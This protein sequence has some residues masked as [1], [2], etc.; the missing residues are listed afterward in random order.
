MP[1]RL[2][3]SS[4]PR[5]SSHGHSNAHEDIL[6]HS[7]LRKLELS[8]LL[9]TVLSP[10]FGAALLQYVSSRVLGEDV[11]SWFSTALFVLATGVRPWA[12]VVKRLSSRVTDLHD[13]IHYPS[14]LEPAEEYRSQLEEMKQQI[15]GFEKALLK[16]RQK[17]GAET[18][19]LYDYVDDA[20]T[21]LEKSVKRHDKR[22]EKYE[23]RLKDLEYTVDR[24]AHAKGKEKPSFITVNTK[25]PPSGYKSLSSLVV[26][27]LP[28]WL[29]PAQAVKSPSHA[30][31][32]LS[33]STIGPK[34]PPR[35]PSYSS[36]E[37]IPEESFGAGFRST[38]VAA[39]VD[40]P[41]ASQPGLIH[42]LFL[43]ISYIATFPLRSIMRLITNSF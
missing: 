2:Y 38:K 30:A 33:P 35:T 1:W 31:P 20:V 9:M 3:L 22:G 29:V 12:H 18:E 28:P 32:R 26:D 16:M 41:P 21:G 43:R 37:T 15:A 11:I 10:F 14:S 25:S 24:L 6:A 27:I 23:T 17:L 5:K 40:R 36:L 8:F 13:V 34:H 19:E 7:E 39:S 42:L 4:R